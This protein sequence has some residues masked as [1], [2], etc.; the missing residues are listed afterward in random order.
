MPTV[1]CRGTTRGTLGANSPVK[2][3]PLEYRVVWKRVGQRRKSKRFAT[4]A[5]AERRVL[6]LGPEPWK[7]YNMEPNDRWCCSGYQCACEGMTAR[8]YLLEARSKPTQSGDDGMP[9]IMYV[10]IEERPVAS[11]VK[12]TASPT[13]AGRT[14]G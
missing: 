3:V 4:L 13:D 14:S 5:A 6:L 11:W 1:Q 12:R 9:A 2:R 10:E 7:A 8:E